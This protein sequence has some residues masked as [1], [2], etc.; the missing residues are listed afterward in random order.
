VHRAGL[1]RS[2][3]VVAG[4]TTPGLMMAATTV[5]LR[6]ALFGTLLVLP[7]SSQVACGQ[8]EWSAGLLLA[9]QGIGAA[10]MRGALAVRAKGDAVARWRGSQ[11]L[12]PVRDQRG[13]LRSNTVATMTLS[14]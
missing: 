13:L 1:D 4:V 3:L 8:S 12:A 5:V 14:S 7:R 10:L 6:P 9:P 2:T 11:S